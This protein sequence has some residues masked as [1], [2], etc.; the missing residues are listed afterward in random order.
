MLESRQNH[1]LVY[2]NQAFYALGGDNLNNCETLSAN[3]IK[4]EDLENKEWESIKPMR[5]P[6]RSF[7]AVLF[8]KNK[9]LVIG[10]GGS[11]IQNQN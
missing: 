5:S 10:S 1:Q 2:C 11:Q 7:G 8:G 3:V 6:R 4:P 9:I